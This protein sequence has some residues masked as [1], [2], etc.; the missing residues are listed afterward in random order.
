MEFTRAFSISRSLSNAWRLIFAAPVALLVGG[1][2][3]V[4]LDGN[5]GFGVSFSDADDWGS[6]RIDAWMAP[7]VSVLFAFGCLVGIL[8]FLGTSWLLCGFANAVEETARTGEDRIATVFDAKGRWLS[9]ALVRLGRAA[10]LVLALLP[11]AAIVV[12]SV[13]LHEGLDLP[14][15]LA[16]VA[17]V[18]AGL[19]YLPIWIYIALGLALVVPAVAL[20]G[21]DPVGAVARSW[22]LV[23]GNRLWLFVYAFVLLIVELAG[24]LA[25]CI[26]VFFTGPLARIAWIDGYL[27]L[28]RGD[29]YV[30]GFLAPVA[31]APMPAAAPAPIDPAATA[32]AP[33]PGP[34]GGTPADAP[35]GTPPDTPES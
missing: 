12:V 17:G 34:S 35:P 23:R 8:F 19:L 15:E 13:I 5:S 20:E 2:L 4:L 11:F 25:C 6:R 24:L 26:G 16:I 32:A 30:D 14:E 21:L 27:A 10:V 33:A 28:T 22:S 29:E 31:P 18:L 9:M 1:G 3:L 7:L